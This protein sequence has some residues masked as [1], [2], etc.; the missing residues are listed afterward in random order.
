MK[1]LSMT[2]PWASLV[3]FGEKTIETRSWSTDYRGRIAIHAAKEYPESARKLA[4]D[5]PFKDLLAAIEELTGEPLPTGAILATVELCAC[6][7]ADLIHRLPDEERLLGDY[8]AGRF[9]WLLREVERFEK[10]IPAS[11][12]LGLWEWCPQSEPCHADVLLEMAKQ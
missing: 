2:Q 7:P 6:V 10:P 5:Q 8:S 11:G 3:A 9:A 1:A 12:A 4:F